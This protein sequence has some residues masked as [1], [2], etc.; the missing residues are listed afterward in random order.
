M[1][2]KKKSI[3]KMF[4]ISLLKSLGCIAIILAVGFISYK[5]SYAVLSGETDQNG[6]TTEI[7]EIQSDATLDEVSKNLI[8]VSD[9][10]NRITHLMLEICNTKTYNMDYVTI[11]VKTDYT[12]P[13]TMYRQLCQINQEI[14]QVIR[15]SK[16]KTY[17]SQED[18]AYG[19]G[20]LIFEKMLGIDISYYT[21]YEQEV[22]DNH[23]KEEKATIAFKTTSDLN[24]TPDPEGVIPK[25]STTLQT[26]MKINVLSDAYKRQLSDLGSDE[27]K[28]L[29]HIKNEYERLLSNLSRENK[30]SY[31]SAYQKMNVNFFHY[32]GVPCTYEDKVYTI[33]KKAAKKAL[34]ALEENSVTYT[35]AQDLSVLNQIISA[36]ATETAVTSSSETAQEDSKKLRIYVLNGSQIAG[37]ASKTKERLESDGY[38]VPE[39]GNYTEQTLTHTRIIVSKKEQGKDLESY[40]EDPERSVGEVAEGYD[41]EIILGTADANQ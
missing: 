37:L 30:S 14:P 9:E 31:I 36:S 17:F 18:D 29:D 24:N 7:E 16:L 33:D 41:I 1:A 15:L 2:M 26:K 5:I 25:S 20:M 6:V 34:K 8:Y 28:I 11:P 32:W 3:A 23:Y 40:F 10:K 21:A 35:A 27:K 22:Y 12:I 19:Y 13:S 38:Q 39:I 4:F